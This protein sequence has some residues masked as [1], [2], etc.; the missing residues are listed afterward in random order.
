MLV[1]LGI[2]QKKEYISTL[3][4]VTM[5]QQAG[6]MMTKLCLIVW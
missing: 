6:L 3:I 4:H 1:I 5:N 2:D